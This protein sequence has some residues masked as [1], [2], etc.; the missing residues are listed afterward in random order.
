[1]KPPHC[2]LVLLLFP[3]ALFANVG[4]VVAALWGGGDVQPELQPPHVLYINLDRSPERDAYMRGWLEQAVGSPY[5]TR[6]AGVDGKLLEDTSASV[7]ATPSRPGEWIV[8]SDKHTGGCLE[9]EFFIDLKLEMPQSHKHI[10]GAGLSHAK[11]IAIAYAMGLEHAIILEDDMRMAHNELGVERTTVWDLVRMV[12]ESLPAN[13]QILQLSHFWAGTRL[14]IELDQLRQGRVWSRRDALLS[15]QAKWGAGSYVISRRG[16]EEFLRSHMRS[17]LH[18]SLADAHQFCLREDFRRSTT[19]VSPDYWIYYTSNVFSLHLPLFLPDSS[20]AAG[21]TVWTDEIKEPG[22]YAVAF[23]ASVLA[24]AMDALPIPRNLR[25]SMA[26]FAG[27][28]EVAKHPAPFLQ[29]PLVSAKENVDFWYMSPPAGPDRIVKLVNVS[30]MRERSI[31]ID[32][33]LSQGELGIMQTSLENFFDIAAVRQQGGKF[34]AEVQQCQSL[35]ALVFFV[36]N[37]LRTM[38]LPSSA[39]A[40]DIIASCAY[41]CSLLYTGMEDNLE[42]ELQQCVSVTG[43]SFARIMMELIPQHQE[44]AAE[45]ARLGSSSPPTFV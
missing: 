36:T 1:M 10:I 26:F 28:D 5:F 6:V 44:Q 35:V 2:P 30:Q 11:A 41:G 12:M 29:L 43:Q 13:W 23:S 16:M 34:D 9:V 14:S 45:N 38:V 25:A 22:S 21:S 15:D 8:Y 4:G 31:L 37:Q 20:V 39:S 27:K 17:Y 40:E 3:L 24:E 32:D 18:A 19:N 33:M 7:A 42:A